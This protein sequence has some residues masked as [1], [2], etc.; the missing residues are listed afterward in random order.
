MI[1]I[2]IT[3]TRRPELLDKTLSTFCR[4]LFFTEPFTPKD[5]YV[6]INVDPVGVNTTSESI[7]SI[8]KDYFPNVKFRIAKKAHFPTAFLWC[9]DMTTSNYVFHLE[10]DWECLRPLSLINMINIMEIPTYKL[11]HLR[12]SQWKSETQLKNWNQFL[13]FNG[14]FFQVPENIKG[15]IGFCGHPSLNT[16]WFIKTCLHDLSELRNPEKQIKWRNKALW[17][18]MEDKTFGCYQLQHEPAAIKDIGRAWM[19]Q[20]NWKKKGSKE[21]FTEWERGRV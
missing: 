8:V 5:Y 16:R 14:S 19:V 3:A 21:W 9:W 11:V 20:N 4:Y 1:D 6:Y 2:T 15:T 17:K 13:D 10:E 18:W 7:V 12:L